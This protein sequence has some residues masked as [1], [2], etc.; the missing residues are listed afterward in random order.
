M[1]PGTGYWS[2]P[3]IERRISDIIRRRPRRWRKRLAALKK[4]KKQLLS[5]KPRPVKGWRGACFRFERFQRTRELLKTHTLAETG[6]L[7]GGI[8]RQRVHQIIS[9]P[10]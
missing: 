5:E 3:A 2:L 10:V 4:A 7:L 1:K 6:K 9:H 8:S